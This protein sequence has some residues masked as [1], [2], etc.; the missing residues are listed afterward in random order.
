MTP[1]TAEPGQWVTLAL[2]GK[3]RGNRGEVTAVPLASKP[4]RYEQLREVYLFGDGQKYEVESAWFH[5]SVLVLKFRGIDSISDAETL[6][7]CE[8]RVPHSQRMPLDAG[9]YY[10]S[11][12][13]G[14]RVIERAT[15]NLLGL[16][17]GFEEAGG[18]GLLAVGPDML[19]PF[20]RSICVEIDIPGRRILVD[21]PTGLKDLNQP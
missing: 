3:T 17:T 2:L 20:A 14:C 18:A 8:V 13:V 19:I 9:E 12:L 10:Q 4:E 7:G 21:L 5:G 1:Q 11:D 16:V 6:S 15:G